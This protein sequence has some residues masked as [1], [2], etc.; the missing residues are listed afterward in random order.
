[1]KQIV[2]AICLIGSGLGAVA[3]AQTDTAKPGVAKV[4]IT[5]PV[6]VAVINFQQAV[7]RRPGFLYQL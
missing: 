3:S 2:C 1:M 6:R 4:P 7:V 5:S